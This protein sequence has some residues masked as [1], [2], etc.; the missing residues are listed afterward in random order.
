MNELKRDRWV[1]TRKAAS[2]VGLGRQRAIRFLTESNVRSREVPLGESR[3]TTQYWL[4]D[5]LNITEVSDKKSG[6]TPAST[7]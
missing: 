7:S 2:I 6:Q 5:I 3:Q 1:T 4:P